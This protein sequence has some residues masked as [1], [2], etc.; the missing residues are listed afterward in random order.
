MIGIGKM[1]RSVY[2]AGYN[3]GDSAVGS[4]SSSIAKISEYMSEGIESVPTI[5][6]IMDLSDVESG[7][8]A[9]N[10]MFNDNMMIGATANVGAISS[11]MNERIQ[12][13]TNDDVVSAINKLGKQLSG[14][15]SNTYNIGGVTYDDGSNISE[16]VESLVS[17]ARVERRR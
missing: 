9:I 4:I 12:N 17:A 3:L 13:G 11:M 8:G 15:N 14:M 10:G 2:K 5:R 6:P 7:V 1:T 16:A